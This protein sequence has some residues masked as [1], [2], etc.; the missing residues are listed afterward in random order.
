MSRYIIGIDLAKLHDYTAVTVLDVAETTIDGYVVRNV[1]RYPVGLEYH[2]VAQHIMDQLSGRPYDGDV[3]LAVDATGLGG[4]VLEQF[5]GQMSPVIGI[6]IT[7]GSSVTRNS[8]DFRVPKIDLVSTL[9]A[10]CE[11]K[12]IAFAPRAK[13]L[14][15]LMQELMAFQG[16][17]SGTGHT[18][19]EGRGAHDDMVMSLAMAAWYAEHGVSQMLKP[20]VYTW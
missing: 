1:Y 13:H 7:A 8:Q 5:R 3:V 15:A 16:R 19:Y 2:R 18:R 11:N 12:R 17:M 10:L 14:D 4:P 9:L 6:S 20:M